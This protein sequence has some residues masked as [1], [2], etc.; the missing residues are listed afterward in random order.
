MVKKLILLGSDPQI[1]NLRLQGVI[2]FAAQIGSDCLLIYFAKELGN[3][4]DDRDCDGKTPLAIACSKGHFSTV[5]FLVA[6]NANV[7]SVDS[8]GDSVLHLATFSQSY[9]IA[10]L[11]LIKGSNKAYRNKLGKTAFELAKEYSFIDMANILVV[12]I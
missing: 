1:K 4:I 7:N 2:H 11:L 3:A 5:S 12:N 9:K 8:S 10:K 6:W